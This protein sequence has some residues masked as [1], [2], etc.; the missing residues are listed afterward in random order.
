M[1]YEPALPAT[2]SRRAT[3]ER[4]RLATMG[5]VTRKYSYEL[6]VWPIAFTTQ[7]FGVLLFLTWVGGLTTVFVAK[8]FQARL[9]LPDTIMLGVV[10]AALSAAWAIPIAFP[11]MN[12]YPEVWVTD[13]AI[14]ISVLFLWR[15]R[16]PWAEVTEIRKRFSTYVVIA[17]RITLLHY[18]LG[19]AYGRTLRPAFILPVFM[20]DRAAL[21]AEIERKVTGN[22]EIRRTTP[23]Q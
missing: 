8:G 6:L 17:E 16:I 7:L 19:W 5:M 2:N 13:D 18:S 22:Q 3:G 20:K 11:L 21:V 4:T 12:S 9:A 15:I 10:V 1:G 23:S 14:T